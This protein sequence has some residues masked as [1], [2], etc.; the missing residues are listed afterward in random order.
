MYKI[1]DQNFE[2]VKVDFPKKETEAAGF[3]SAAS[4]ATGERNLDLKVSEF[5]FCL[6][7]GGG[8]Y[9]KVSGAESVSKLS[10]LR[11]V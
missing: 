8:R 3:A 9:W 11:S 1:V 7:F 2:R 5:N 4:S 10:E 6:F